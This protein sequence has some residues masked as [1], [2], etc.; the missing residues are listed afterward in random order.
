MSKLHDIQ[1]V[2][3]NKKYIINQRL[4]DE[5]ETGKTK[6]EEVNSPKHYNSYPI[7][8]ID[9]MIS[10]FGKEKV[11]DFCII[12]AFKYRMRMGCKD[13]INQDYEKE[14]WYLNKAKELS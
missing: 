10:V 2:F 13:D 12:N 8:V 9:M 3:P 6:K 7:E 14:Q 5:S 1:S 4:T 11:K